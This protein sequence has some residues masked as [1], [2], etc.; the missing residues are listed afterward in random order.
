MQWFQRHR[1]LQMKRLATTIAIL[2][3]LA[4]TASASLA[5]APL[6]GDYKS[7]DIGGTIPA[8]RYTEGWDLGGGALLGG[9]TQNCGSWDGT[10]LDGVW[11]YTCG[12]ATGPAMLIGG[13]VSPQGNGNR[14]Y[15]VTYTG[16]TFWLSGTGPWANGDPDYPGVFDSYV[17]YETIQYSNWVPISAVTNVQSAAHFDNYGTFCMGFSIGNGSRVGTTDLGN[18]MPAGYPAM[19][20]PACAPTRTRGAWWNFTSI[21]IVL[22]P[23]C[24]TSAKPSTWG[25]L[26]AIYR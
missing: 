2:A 8:G 21:T 4:L 23:D 7:T 26:K 25:S 3:A 6:P 16:G 24:A 10:T 19:L 13:Y 15:M 1:R 20:T 5:A 22:T 17:E 11:K 14:T 12:T 9:T 18:V